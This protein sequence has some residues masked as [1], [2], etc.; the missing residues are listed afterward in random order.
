MTCHD[1]LQQLSAY[2]DG[3]LDAVSTAALQH[4]LATCQHCRTELERVWSLEERLRLTFR[5]E[6][7]PAT[8]WPRI[9]AGLER[10]A[11]PGRAV[12]SRQRLPLRFWPMVVAAVLLL[13]LGG[14]LFH[15]AVLLP[16]ALAT[17]VLSVPVQDLQT[18]VVSQRSLDMADA[19]P[20]HLRQW[21][22]GKVD[23]PPP[24]V[25]TQVGSARLVGGRLCYFLD[26]RVASFMYT[27]AGR[28]LSLYVMPRQG[29]RSP[30][31]DGVPLPRTPA[32]VYEVQ[33]YTHIL[34]WHTDLLY[35]LVSDLPQAQL[36]ELAQGLVAA[37]EF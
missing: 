31:G 10:H 16:H 6:P 36:F 24:L 35:S 34:W 37:G 30:S 18:F 23:F 19:D 7:V 12:E 3:T 14:A 11:S 13:A 25:P 27:T 9:R 4:H 22:Q 8:L 28:Y 20:Q 26:R 2:L 29:L 1:V 15:R 32:R 21:F 17:R 33:G 5:T